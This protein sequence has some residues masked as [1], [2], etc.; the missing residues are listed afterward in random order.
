M[1]A[2]RRP[3]SNR[4]DAILAAYEQR[5]YSYDQVGW[6]RSATAPAG[7]FVNRGEAFL[8]QGESV[9]LRA[10]QTLAQ[11]QMFPTDWIRAYTREPAVAA[12]NVVAT[13]ARCAG[14]WAVNACRVVYVD[15]I[16]RDA[17]ESLAIGY[18]TLRGHLMRGEERFR[19]SWDH[20]DDA[21]RYDVWSFSWPDRFAARCALP[22]IRRIQRRFAK[23]SPV[24]M[25]KAISGINQRPPSSDQEGNY[26]RNGAITN[27]PRA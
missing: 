24:A 23:E 1:F 12:G 22:L 13:V 11:W 2:L 5:Q 10:R 3:D 4:L 21:V 15:D 8:G 9:F 26:C 25:Q 16:R 20:R 27:R 17:V 18:G 7:A 19:V 14:L 6:S